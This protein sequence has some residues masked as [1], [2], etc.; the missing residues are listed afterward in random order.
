MEKKRVSVTSGLY[1]KPITIINDDSRVINKLETSLTDN[2]RVVVY[3]CHMF[4]VQA[5][6]SRRTLGMSIITNV[7]SKASTILLG[8]KQ[9]GAKASAVTVW[10]CHFRQKHFASVN[11]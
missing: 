9:P 4:I 7:I 3:D 1:Y 8:V 11:L 2:T 5:I 10:E 6:G